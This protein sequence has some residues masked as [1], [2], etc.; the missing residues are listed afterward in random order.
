MTPSLVL[1]F[2]GLDYEEEF[3]VGKV[4]PSQQK[5]KLIDTYILTSVPGHAER[6]KLFGE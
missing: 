4:S 1:G 5:K 2:N 6:Q 3:G